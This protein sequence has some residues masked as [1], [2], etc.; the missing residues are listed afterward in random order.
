MAKSEQASAPPLPASANAGRARRAELELHVGQMRQLFNAM[1]PAPFRERDLDP[2]AEEYIVDWGRETHAGAPLGLVV[3]LS[4]E[5]ATPE[6]AALLLDAVHCYFRQRAE[7][8]R[9]KLRQLFRVGRVS[10]LIGLA[11]LAGAIVIGEFVAS[12]VGKASYGGI[13]KE[14]FVIGGWVAL[15]RPLEIFLYDWWPIRA[16]ATLFDRLSEMD[17]RVLDASPATAAAGAAP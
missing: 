1:D 2:N 13:I 5:P 12:L 10:L 4:R 17:V 7:A 3:R 15:W 9:R 14:S 16:E 6:C 11:F 8:T